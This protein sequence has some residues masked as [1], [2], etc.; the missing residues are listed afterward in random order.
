M[1]FLTKS[2][3]GIVLKKM[4]RIGLACLLTVFFL[5]GCTKPAYQIQATFTEDELAPYDKK[6]TA[7]VV[8]QAFLKTK[9]GDVKYAAGNKVVLMPVTNYTTEI[10]SAAT[11]QHYGKIDNIEPGLKKYVKVSM[12][13]GEGRFEFKDIPPGNYYVCTHVK[14]QVPTAPYGYL[15]TT[16][17]DISTTITVG[18]GEKVKVVLTR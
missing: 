14:W 5:F 11:T 2:L 9:G 13:D 7:T 8:G 10:V 15:Q 12:A 4:L 6:G 3:E 1:G 18:E 17:G 16:G